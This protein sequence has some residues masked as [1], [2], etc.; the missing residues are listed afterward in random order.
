MKRLLS[1]MICAGLLGGMLCMF[2]GCSQ[3][4]E[5]GAGYLFTYTMSE[6]PACLDPQYTD[7]AN[8][9]VVI[10]NT[11]E[12][13]LRFD[14]SS[15]EPVPAGAESYSVSEDGLTYMFNLRADCYWYRSDMQ[16]GQAIPV[17]AQDYVYAFQRIFN[18][19]THSPY[20]DDF[21]CLKNAAAITAGTKTYTE[22]GVSAPDD[23]TIIFTLEYPNAEFP[24][25]V[26]QPCAVPCN[27]A[28]FLSTNGRY[29]LDLDTFMS[30]G[31]F[32][33][34][35]WNYDAYGGDNFLSLRKSKVYYD[36]DAVFPSSLLFS[37]MKTQTAA[38]AS[39]AA[40]DG[41]VLLTDLYTAE[42]ADEKEYTIETQQA[43][44]LG[45][46]F[47]PANETA[48]NETL[49]LA[50]AH[51][52]N[53][54]AI[55]PQLSGD[56]QTAYGIIPPAAELLGRS[57]RELYAEETLALPYDPE[58]AASLFASAAEELGL[59][60]MNTMKILVSSEITD[61]EALLAI[62]Q[63]WQNLF[64]YYIGI[65]T[66][67]PAEFD[68]RI[69]EGEYS[70][71]LYPMG[72]SKGSCYSALREFSQKSDLLGFE[73]AAYAAIMPK[74]A[75]AAQLSESLE[76]YGAAEKAIIETNTFI[77]LF[78]KSTYLVSTAGN[79]DIGFNAFSRVV[80]FRDAKHFS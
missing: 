53:R 70:I 78:Y 52:I 54:S 69:A 60:S 80:Y 76:L 12:G 26:A 64:G 10:A 13:L 38:E 48:S 37:I 77:P 33:L 50:L 16:E 61:T 1:C 29:G 63:E 40:G 71:A 19:E 31:P 62:C 7:N 4:E 27:E 46:I 68:K 42:Y 44:T 3:S 9:A 2:S 55:S 75:S 20:T 59:Y 17:T 43:Q 25:L 74:I 51:G 36:A 11:M 45:L 30:N 66:V 47:N 56:L 34:T 5:T 79:R 6:N 35:K 57:Y 72:G 32:Y 67:T 28:F 15:S 22:I 8:A 73:S 41:D 65:E 39:F 18:P 21:L 49:R 24:K 58:L 14:G 23:T